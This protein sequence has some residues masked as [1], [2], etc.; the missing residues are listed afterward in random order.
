MAKGPLILL[1]FWM[2]LTISLAAC[3]TQDS[4][5]NLQISII[6]KHASIKPGGYQFFSTSVKDSQGEVQPSMTLQWSSNNP[7]VATVTENGLAAAFQEGT[8]G[9]VVS[10]GETSTTATLQVSA[11]AVRPI[12]VVSVVPEEDTTLS[13]SGCPLPC[14]GPPLLGSVGAAFSFPGEDIFG[15]ARL[16]LDGTEVTLS[17]LVTTDTGVPGVEGQIFYNISGVSLAPG[18]HQITVKVK[19]QTGQTVTY[20]WSFTITE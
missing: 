12:E 17:A 3:N 13:L 9:I 1:F 11:S 2:M 16:F 19:S 10:T 20:A 5:S 14:L 4:G 15:S 6:P 8:A 18:S 7:E